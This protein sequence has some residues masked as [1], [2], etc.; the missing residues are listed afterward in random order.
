MISRAVRARDAEF[1]DFD[2]WAKAVFAKYSNAKLHEER[3]KD[4]RAKV[5]MVGHDVVGKYES[6][7][8]KAMNRGWVK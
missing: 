2:S 7:G 6:G 5:A 4:G 1:S 8:T 3:L